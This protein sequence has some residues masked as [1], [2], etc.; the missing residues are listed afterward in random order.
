MNDFQYVGCEPD[1]FKHGI[2]WKRYWSAFIQTYL[3]GEVLEVGAGIGSN[4]FL[5]RN[6]CQRR[7]VCLEPDSALAERLRA[8]LDA[9]K[10]IHLCEVDVGTLK[11]MVAEA[12]FDVII[13]IDV[14]EHIEDDK[15]EL[16]RAAGRLKPGGLLI[17]LAPAHEWLYSRFDKTVGHYRRYNKKM[18]AAVAPKC[19]KLERLIYLDCVGL[20][21]SLANRL[22]L[23]QPLPSLRQI[24]VWDGIM[25]PCSKW[26]DALLFHYIGKSVLG[27]W[28][29]GP[30]LQAKDD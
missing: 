23:K 3:H 8:L 27:V 1:L 7:W 21:A 2:N 29:N 22:L 24:K 25:I 4:T 13:Y 10:P 18:L 12:L 28:R 30:E 26:L 9:R 17:V 6:Y 15:G 16:T 14:L 19:L 11:T 20:C 5:L